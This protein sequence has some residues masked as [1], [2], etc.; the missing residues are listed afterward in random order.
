M[1]V[2]PRDVLFVD[3]APLPVLPVCQHFAGNEKFITKAFAQQRAT[4]T[5]TDQP[6]AVFDVICDLE[7]GAAA[8]QE[9]QTAEMIGALIAGSDNTFG[10]AGVR[11]HD[12]THPHC[13]KDVEIVVRAAAAKL[14][15][16]TLPKCDSR[17]DAL[18]IASYINHVSEEVGARRIIPMHVMIETHRGLREVFDIVELPQVQGV[19]LGIMD[20]VSSF[21]GAIPAAAMASPGQFEHPLARRAALEI[22]TAGL[23]NGAVPIHPVTQ[24]YKDLSVVANDARRARSE[25]GYLAKYSIHPDQIAPIVRGMQPG[26]HEIDDACAIL[27]AAQAKNW[28]PVGHNGKL[29]DRASYRY[30]WQ[31]LDRAH[32]T[33]ASVPDDARKAF[34]ATA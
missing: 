24:D 27:L 9:R 11:I 19:T 15:F 8:G 7:D 1:P 18:K 10:R 16:I 14:A 31:L 21:Q 26:Q 32:Q 23:G 34:F 12:A 4:A 30:F 5:A 28:G 2:H 17:M 33:G 25:F 6:R 20:F 29:H 22:S 13:M 3:G